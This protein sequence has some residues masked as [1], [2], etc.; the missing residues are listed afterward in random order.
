MAEI[1]KAINQLLRTMGEM[2]GGRK[3]GQAVFW[4]IFTLVV[5]IMIKP[6]YDNASYV[7]EHLTSSPAIV[8]ALFVSFAALLSMAVM[9][10]VAGAIATLIGW[11]IRVGL[12]TPTTIRI[13]NTLNKFLP[14]LRKAKRGNLDRESINELL[15]D[16][17]ELETQWN[18]SKIVKFV[19]WVK[20]PKFKKRRGG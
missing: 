8:N 15:K 3:R 6:A 10:G 18:K 14:L 9:F 13:D 5:L 11:S 2:A 7:I 1:I 4:V 19:H 12:A 20:K 17:K 16:T